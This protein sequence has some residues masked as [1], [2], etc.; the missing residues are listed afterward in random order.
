[1]NQAVRQVA[2]DAGRTRRAED[3]TPARRFGAFAALMLF[4]FFY[5][6][7][8]NTVDILRP[9]I[10]DALGLSLTQAGSAYT[11]QGLGALVGAIVLGQL[12]DRFGRTRMIYVVVTGYAALGLLGV[13]VTSYPALLAQRGALGFFLGG[14]FPIIVGSYLGLFPPH[15]RGKLTSVGNGCYNLAIVALGAA[16]AAAWLPKD[17]RF[18]LLAGA[19]PPLLLSPLLTIVP[20]DRRISAWGGRTTQAAEVRKLP[21]ADLFAPGLIGITVRLFL[22]IGLNFFAY[23]AFA[24]WVTTYL[25]DVRGFTPAE[26]GAIVAWQFTGATLGSFFWGWVTDR[27]GR[28]AAALGFFGATLVVA[29][30]LGVLQAP[31]ALRLA[32][33]LWGFMIAC[34]VA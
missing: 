25:K 29:I 9:Q 4:E 14:N 18:L 31:A 11:A 17:W 23:Q 27:F 13:V 3:L 2:T 34:S 5:G 28:R 33:F 10:R 32:G 19:L 8:W 22:V 20:D 26:G 7:C 1:M 6:W 21:I 12:A 16:L 24:G 15:L 30:Y